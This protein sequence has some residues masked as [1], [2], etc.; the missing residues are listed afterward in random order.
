MV[1]FPLGPA[2]CTGN[3]DFKLKEVRKTVLHFMPISFWNKGGPKNWS[4]PEKSG[5]ALNI[6]HW[7]VFGVWG[8]FLFASLCLGEGV[9]EV[10]TI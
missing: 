9:R 5:T 6:V 4:M 7:V 10:E 3:T 2:E 8:H 1:W